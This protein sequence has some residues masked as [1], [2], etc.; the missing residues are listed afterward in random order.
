MNR[1][2]WLVERVAV[3]ETI[4]ECI[5]EEIMDCEEAKLSEPVI[6]EIKK[7]LYGGM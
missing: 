2:E 7:I 4:L 5:L 6:E 1:N 3:L